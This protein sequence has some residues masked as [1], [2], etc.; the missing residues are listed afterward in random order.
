MVNN[1]VISYSPGCRGHFFAGILFG[2]D[3]SMSS[4]C[5]YTNNTDSVVTH[6]LELDKLKKQYPQHKIIGFDLDLNG[7]FK[8]QYL[9]WNKLMHNSEKSYTDILMQTLSEVDYWYDRFS[10]SRDV[11]KLADYVIDFEKTTDYNYICKVY[12]DLTLSNMPENICAMVKHYLKNQ[13]SSSLM[14]E[15]C[16]DPCLVAVVIAKF[17][18]T[19]NL[20]QP[21]WIIKDEITQNTTA[22]KL[23][24]LLTVDTWI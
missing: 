18:I 21:Q 8:A 12:K 9:M 24:S 19:N 15:D 11:A 14:L 2:T 17:K 16:K 6:D 13:P 4:E 1:L 3:V 22:E 5:A 7:F 10:K 20:K 23:N